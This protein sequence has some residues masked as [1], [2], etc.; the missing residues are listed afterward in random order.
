[1]SDKDPHSLGSKSRIQQI[2]HR[3]GWKAQAS[4]TRVWPP[5]VW[6]RLRS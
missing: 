5:P 2:S 6:Q 3:A 4:V 1:M